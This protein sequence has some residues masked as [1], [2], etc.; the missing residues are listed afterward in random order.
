[1]DEPAT[2]D[3][4]V[5]SEFSWDAPNGSMEATCRGASEMGL[6]GIAFTDHADYR[7]GG[8]RFDLT[9]Y[10]DAIEKC[11]S[12]FPNL[13]ILTGVE[14]GE[15]H[16]FR[17]QAEALLRAYPFDLVLGSCHSIQIDDRLVFIGDEG[18]LE[19]AVAHDNVRAFFA[20][21]LDL[22]ERDPVFGALTHLDYP[23]RDWPHE[24][25]VYSDGDFEEEIRAVLVAA[26]SAGLAL[27]INTNGGRLGY[28]PCPGPAVVGWW[29]ESGGR[30][31]TIG[32][33]AHSPK[34]LALGHEVARGMADAL[35]F[36]SDRDR[37]GFWFR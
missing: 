5:H 23:K 1:M 37:F 19:P 21:T 33:D 2:A 17:E 25:L 16:R 14:L 27:E 31:I 18:T 34:R 7:D 32:S 29:A 30:A 12:K 20:E 26:A 24:A 8:G 22:V 35:G 10:S 28:G 4:H 3:L 9:D 13:R 36:R 11:R 15:P 6:P